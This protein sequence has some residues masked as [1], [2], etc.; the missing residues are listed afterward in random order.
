MPHP[1]PH[2]AL[3]VLG[4][5]RMETPGSLPPWVGLHDWYHKSAFIVSCSSNGRPLNSTKSAASMVGCIPGRYTSYCARV[6]QR[7]AQRVAPL[8]SVEIWPGF[9]WVPRLDVVC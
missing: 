9:G 6:M 1:A 4:D 3:H 7:L 8:V 2:A 5:E